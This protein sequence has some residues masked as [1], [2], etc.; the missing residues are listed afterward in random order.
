M[1]SKKLNK[2]KLIITLV[3]GVLILALVVKFTLSSKTA[4]YS[5]ETVKT[6][7]IATYYNFSGN[8]ES[9]DSQI[10]ASRSIL[11]IK[12][13]YVKEGD[14]VKKGDIL[15]TLDDSHLSANVEQ[16]AASLEISKINYEK[17][18]STTKQ[19][20]MA[21]VSSTLAVAQLS[22]NDSKA[23]LEKITELY[24]AGSVAMQALD[25]AQSGYDSAKLQLESA[26]ENYNLTEQSV[27]QNIRTAK[28]QIHQSEANYESVKKQVEDL[29]V[30]S[31]IDGEVSDIYV[32]ENDS[33]VSGIRIMDIVDYGSLEIIV[34]VDEYDIGAIAVGKEVNVTIN[35]LEK[36][37]IG[38]VSKISNQ[39]QSVNE[40]SFF[41]AKISLEHDKDLRVG[42]SAEVKTL[43][44]NVTNATT[45]SMKA[46]QFDNENQPFVYYRNLNNKII[47]K[48]VTLGINDGNT[49]QI[50]DGV[51][52]GEVVL[53]PDENKKMAIGPG[54][55]LGL[56]G[57]KS[58]QQGGKNNE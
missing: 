52:S 27:E 15:F 28:E 37:V 50:I 48:P 55:G 8:I 57:G 20:Q 22:F 42:L 1:K 23:N 16:S 32:N 47:A 44:E 26:K 46:L 18:A 17:M 11:P 14:L 25:Q 6:Q 2:K 53:L 5:E 21:Q 3:L 36:D 7:D 12:K 54:T 24:D 40:V 45:I 4:S 39:A 13:L 35:T 31:E 34:K 41:T 43:N 33:L 51:K 56:G 49:V 58:K 19:Q 10:V 38:V 9:T 30:V 29:T